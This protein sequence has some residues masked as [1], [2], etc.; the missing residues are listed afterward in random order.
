MNPNCPHCRGD[1]KDVIKFGTF[2][3]HTDSRTVRRFRCNHCERHFSQATLSARYRQKKR[4]INHS[5]KLLLVS[6]VS[7]RRI[8]LILNISRT[9]VSRRLNSLANE[10]RDRQQR[11]L[12]YL[13]SF[14]KLQFD[15]LIT[16]EHSKLKPLSVTVVVD[17]ERWQIAGFCVA[18]IPASGLIAAASRKKYGRR[19]D[20][21]RRA[22][23]QL[24]TQLAPFLAPDILFTTDKHTDYTQL[25]GTL[26]PDARHE[27]YKG[28]PACVAGQGELK[29]GGFDPLFCI[30]HVL[31]M[32]R[33]NINRLIR[34][35][36]CTTKK[37]E[38]LRDHLAIFVDVYNAQLSPQK[39]WP[40]ITKTS[41]D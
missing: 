3:R 27:H 18:Q 38:C 36:W 30:N 6:N 33:A 10:A 29:K 21:S 14:D 25:I 24:F 4:R 39:Q 16:I 28:Q 23:R 32:L 22:R 20:H 15:D 41:M 37:P 11:R 17:P 5:I 31:A 26:F 2:F 35:T 9:T 13:S 8:A 1:G 34:R 7:M 19:A 12:Q 40:A